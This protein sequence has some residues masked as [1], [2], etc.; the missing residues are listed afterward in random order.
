MRKSTGLLSIAV[1]V[2]AGAA[3]V[4]RYVVVP[5]TLQL[6]STVDSTVTLT[7][8]VDLFD[9]AALRS[10][11]AAG[12]VRRDV[13]VTVTQRVKVESAD[14]ATAVVSDE[15]RMTGPGATTIMSSR[16]LWAVDRTTLAEVTTASGSTASGTTVTPHTGLVVGFPLTPEPRDYPYWDTTTQ[17]SVTARYLRAENHAGRDAY[18][19]QV[20]GTGAVKDPQVLATVPTALPKEALLAF[21]AGL[22]GAGDAGRPRAGAAGADPVELP[23]HHRHDVL[24]RHAHRVRA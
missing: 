17:T 24:G 5:A 9:E 10:G 7:G 23:G 8:T 15:T 1:I 22:P 4:V 2:L 11:N 14:G 19:Y 13:P 21:A 6:P 12:V 16:N 3:G 18:V 20:Q